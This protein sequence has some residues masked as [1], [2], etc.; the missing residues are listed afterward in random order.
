MNDVPVDLTT[1]VIKAVLA[2]ATPV[3]VTLLTALLV[4][5]LQKVGLSVDA[6]RKAKL[7]FHAREA[8]LRAEEWAAA[9]IK[10][11]TSPSAVTARMK[12]EKAVTDLTA[13]FPGIDRQEAADLIHATL[14]KMELG[15]ASFL[16][17][18]RQAATTDAPK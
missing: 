4:K 18:L 15:A 13:K 16:Q 9:I 17:G 14:P 7:E 12:L 5:A 2:I 8:I 6:D 10:A 11:K 3:L 1:E